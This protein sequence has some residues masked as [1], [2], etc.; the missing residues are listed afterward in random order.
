MTKL[1]A[2]VGGTGFADIAGFRE[3]R[4]ERVVTPYGVASA[5]LIYGALHGQPMVTLQRHGE[6]RNI[7]PHK[8]N[9]RANVWALQ[10]AG[11]RDVIGVAAVGGITADAEPTR[12]VIPEQILDYTSAREHTFYAADL[13]AVQHIDF[14]YPYTPSLR[15]QLL[16][17]A[18]RADVDALDGGVYG[19]TQGPR[20]ETAA[21]VAK[22]ERD[23]CSVVG[24]TGMPEAALMRELGLRYACCAVVV[25]WAA[26]KTPEA[27]T[28]DIIRTNLEAGMQRVDS[29]LAAFA[30]DYAMDDV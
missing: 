26:G 4:R 3:T 22:L 5:P 23:G 6:R 24:M 14:T 18:A 17:A 21:E 29:L 8:V 15:K 27:I 11:V 9:Y 13:E 2:V 16:R 19:A 12:V 20:L 25:N 30:S 7:P 10:Q 1:L 28:M